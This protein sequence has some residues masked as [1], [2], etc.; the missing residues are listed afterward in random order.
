MLICKCDKCGSIMA[1]SE[2]EEIRFQSKRYDFQSKKYDLC[3]NCMMEIE[4]IIL[5]NDTQKDSLIR[6]YTQLLKK[7]K[8]IAF[9][10]AGLESVVMLEI[11][12]IFNG[13][14]ME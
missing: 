2:S 9:S 14:N 5:E 13:E 10:P 1:L 12:D 8:E 11:R 6:T 7:I 4:Q 3:K